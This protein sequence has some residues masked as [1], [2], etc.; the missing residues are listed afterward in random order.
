MEGCDGYSIYRDRAADVNRW[1]RVVVNDKR[2]SIFHGMALWHLVP[3]FILMLKFL[4]ERC[5]LKSAYPFDGSRKLLRYVVEL[6][7]GPFPRA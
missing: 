7:T 5:T 3:T 4:E 2:P 1:N 6:L